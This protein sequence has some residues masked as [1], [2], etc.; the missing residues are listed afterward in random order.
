MR[1]VLLD[2]MLDDVSPEEEEMLGIQKNSS[3]NG[4]AAEGTENDEKILFNR[5][6]R[7]IQV[8]NVLLFQI[9][10]AVIYCEILLEYI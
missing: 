5:D 6:E 10:Y 8:G 3:Y 4:T 9:V 1:D 7:V 2:A